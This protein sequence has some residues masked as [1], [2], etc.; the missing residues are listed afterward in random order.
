MR[1]T[2]IVCTIGPSTSSK[3][4]LLK[5]LKYGMNV[6][7]L[8][9]SHGK[10][11]S[12][13]KIINSINFLSKKYDIPIAILLDTKG[14]EIRTKNLFKKKEVNLISG[15]KF[16]LTT[17]KNIVG[18]SKIVS[19]TH[20]KLTNDLKVGDEVLIDDGLIKMKVKKIK[21]KKIFCKVLNSG[22]LGEN[23]SINLPGIKISLP[24]I[25]DKD[26]EDILFG[27]RKNIDFIA[28]SFVRKRQDV[29]DIK[30]YLKENKGENVQIISKI[31]NQEGLNNFDEILKESDGIMVARGDLGVEIPVEEVIFAQKMI[32]KKCNYARKP[33]ITATQ[34]LESMI[35]NP[36]PTRAEAGD[37]A[38]AIIDGTDAVM[39]SGESAKGSY[40]LESLKI[41]AKI[42]KKTDNNTSFFKNKFNN[43]EYEIK[44]TEAICSSAVEI[45]EKLNSSIIIVSTYLGK[46]AKSIRKYS[47]RAKVIAMTSNINTF[48]QLLICKGVITKFVNKIDSIEK[49]YKLGKLLAIKEFKIKKGNIIIMVSGNITN[50]NTISVQVI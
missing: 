13:G 21:E 32:I 3:K 5:M 33:V 49:F 48:K 29:L 6:I 12:H 31:E 10:N 16:I 1:K 30:E 46:S 14:P 25:S 17:E 28:I 22:V 27:I 24:Y 15:Q 7:R 37:V 35:K 2:K 18:N 45:S 9:L 40:P 4:M 36:R 39:L 50:T 26:K 20:N 23:K 19:V 34:M 42:C 11:E 38:N 47:P 41:M 43:N 8:N 44:I